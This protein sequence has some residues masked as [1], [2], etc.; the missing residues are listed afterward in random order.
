MPPSPSQA[1]ALSL[2]PACSSWSIPENPTQGLFCHTLSTEQPPL[3]NRV[4]PLPSRRMFPQAWSRWTEIP[5]A[6]SV[7]GP[8]SP[9]HRPV[10]LGRQ[11]LHLLHR[12]IW[13]SLGAQG[14]RAPGEDRES[15]AEARPSRS[16]AKLQIL[17]RPGR[18]WKVLTSKWASKW[19]S[20]WAQRKAKD[21]GRVTQEL[22]CLGAEPGSRKP[23]FSRRDVKQDIQF[24]GFQG[25]RHD[26]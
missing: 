9:D 21:G 18:L 23:P 10:S 6:V 16:L 3:W 5:L 20:T 8:W 24:H 17:E 19:V 22:R 12:P 2:L 11:W 1:A 26:W 15:T 4:S 25:L 7:L 14:R 13:G